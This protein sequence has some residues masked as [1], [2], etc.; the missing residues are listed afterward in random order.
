MADFFGSLLASLP[1]ASC[2]NGFDDRGNKTVDNTR[3]GCGEAW[4]D[5]RGVEHNPAKQASTD[6]DIVKTW[7][8]EYGLPLEYGLYKKFVNTAGTTEG[9]AYRPTGCPALPDNWEDF[10]HIQQEDQGKSQ[11]RWT[12]VEDCPLNDYA[13]EG[14]ALHE[15]VEEMADDHDIFARNFLA[16]YERMIENGYDSDVELEVAPVN[17]WFGYYTMAGK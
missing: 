11:F 7:T 1:K 12:D 9:T 5:E 13:P 14:K 17:S 15:I 6:E 4:I 8:G 10:P 3:K 2:F 16:G